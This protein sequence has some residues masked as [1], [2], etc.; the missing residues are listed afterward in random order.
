MKTPVATEL[1]NEYVTLTPLTLEEAPAY[2]QIGST[3]DIWNY[4]APDPFTT[5]SDAENWIRGMLKR[6]KEEGEVPFSVYDKAT[7]R[8]AGSSSYLEVRV[9][10]GGLEIGWTWY[11]K[12]FQRTHVNS[13]TKLALLTHAFE[14][15]GANR[16]QLQTDERNEKSQ[17]AIERL[18]AI[19]EGVLRKHKVY[20]NGYVRNSVL[21]SVTIDEWPNVKTRLQGFLAKG[22]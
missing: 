10:H 4:L 1:A 8:L 21:Y 12:E 5:L 16:V 19:K 11:G 22:A 6:A 20:P 13:A 9:P 7:G 2:L 15:L 17:R 14:E 18:G 3:A